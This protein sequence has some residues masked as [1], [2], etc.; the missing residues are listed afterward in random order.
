MLLK[1]LFWTPCPNWSVFPSSFPWS[2]NR[3]CD[4]F[5]LWADHHRLSPVR[6]LAKESV[7]WKAGVPWP[8]DGELMKEGGGG[9]SHPLLEELCASRLL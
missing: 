9:A 4:F 7:G 3:I 2:L 8:R 5:V 6:Q 1:S